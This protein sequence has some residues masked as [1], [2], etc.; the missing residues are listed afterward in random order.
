MKSA[1]TAMQ[2]ATTQ[3]LSPQRHRWHTGMQMCPH[4]L[5]PCRLLAKYADPSQAGTSLAVIDIHSGS[6]TQ[7][8]T[9][10]SSYSNIVAAE[11]SR[12]PDMHTHPSRLAWASA[13]TPGLQQNVTSLMLLVWSSAVDTSSQRI[14]IYR[15]V[16]HVQAC[17]RLVARLWWPPLE[18]VRSSLLSLPC[19]RLDLWRSCRRRV[20]TSGV[21]CGRA[22]H[23]RQVL[24]LPRHLKVMQHGRGIARPC[25]SA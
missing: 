5:L 16:D 17:C 21:P 13:A 22:P 3:A 12:L 25:L 8:K 6:V 2:L 4:L 20:L 9:K 10:Y 18:A 14:C 7:L 24:F 1:E 15:V 11:A 23:W 19:W